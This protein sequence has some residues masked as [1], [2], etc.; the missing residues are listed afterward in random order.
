M[1]EFLPLYV[2]EHL[3]RGRFRWDAPEGALTPCTYCG[4]MT[5]MREF[6]DLA[7]GQ[8]WPAC[9]SRDACLDQWRPKPS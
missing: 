8:S 4:A 1:S 2:L 7:T 5:R 6:T 3:S 9:C